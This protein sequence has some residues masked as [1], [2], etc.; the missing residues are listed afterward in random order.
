MHRKETCTS[1]RLLGL[2]VVF[3]VVAL[4][5]VAQVT[6]STIHGIVRDPSGAAIPAADLKLTDTATGIVKATIAGSEGT[7][8]FTNLVAGTYRL[9]ATAPGF[10]NAVLDGV[11][12]DAG[13]ITDV[14]VSMTV[15]STNETVEVAAVGVQLETTSNEI[16]TTISNNSIHNLPYP[17]RDSLFFALLMAGSAN[18]ND[19]SGR[20]STYNGLPN[21]SLNITIDGMNDNSQRFK[22]GGTSF[23]AFAPQR[24]DAIEEVTVSTT[25][26]GADAVGEGAMNVRFTTKRGTDHYHFLMGEQFENEALNANL[27]FA[28]LRGQHIPRGRQNNAYGSIG[29]PLVP[30]LPALKHKLFFF[31]YMEGQPQPSS[32]IATATVFT[33]AA[34]AGNFTYIGTDGATRTVNLLTSAAA[35]GYTSTV[36][37]TVAGILGAI[38]ASESKATGFLGIT[39]QPYWQTMQFV[40]PANTTYLFPTA[41]VDYQITPKVAWHG[42][43]NLKW[44]FIDGYSNYPDM[45]QYLNANSYKITTY[46]ATNSVDWTITPRMV[47]NFTFGVQSNLEFFNPGTNPYQWSIYG[48][49]RIVMPSFSGQTINPVVPTP[50]PINRNNPVFQV[51]D[52]LSWVKGQHT[53][54]IG[55]TMLHTSF[56]EAAY[57]SAGVP[58]YN[59]GLAS[60]D[61]VGTPLQ[62]ALPFINTVNGDLTNAQNLYALLT[63]RVA[64]ISGTVNV[65]E[66]TLQY[67]QFSPITNRFAF[68]TAGVYIQD[69]YRVSPRLALNFGVR[70][71]FDDTIKVANGIVGEPDGANFFGPSNGLF[72]PGVLN[73][74]LN[75][76]INNVCSPYSAD[77]VNPATNVGFAWNPSG[78]GAF[79]KLL[80]RGRTVIR[81]A[82]A[83]T[84]FNEGLD[85]ISNL[86][87]NNQGSTQS[88]SAV[89]GNAGFPLGGVNLSSPTP[90]LSVFPSAFG[91]PVPEA[92]YVFSG[93]NA[94][95]LINPHLVSP[96]VQ[97]WNLGIQRELPSHVAVE[98]RYVGNRST[99]QWHYQNINEVNIFENG[100]LP[101]FVQAQQN[102]AVNQANG[103]G[104]TFINNGLPGQGPIPIFET[105][106][107]ASGS[108]PALAAAS[109]FSN[110]GFI[111]NLQQGLAG[112]M[113]NSLASTSANTYYCRLVGSKFAPCANVGFTG[114]TPYPINFFTPN[115]FATSL[116]YQDDNGSNNYNG[117]QIEA[118]KA[119]THGLTGTVN[120]T[121]S[122]AMGNELN[123]S[124]DSATYT[125]FT[126]RNGRLSYG[127]SPF[128]RR[129]A[130]NSYWTYDLPFGKNRLINIENP[131]LDRVF[132]GWTLGGVETIASGAPNIVNSARMTVNNIGQSGV[133]LGSGLTQ[134]QF[135]QDLAS[136][137]DMNRVVNGNLIANVASIAQT[138]G[139]PNPTFY[140][141]ATTPG[142]FGQ[143]VYLYG[144]TNFAL[145]MSL[146]K[147]VRIREHLNIGFRVE[148]LNFLNHPFFPIGNTSPTANTFGQI[149]S[150]VSSVGTT[151]GTQNANF[152]RVVLLRAY[153]SW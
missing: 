50:L 84:Y 36:D 74:N 57:N 123:A 59:L 131:V 137:P 105:A 151:Y 9:T 100:F 111:T 119:T 89:P 104:V 88:I 112:S 118:R 83:L 98:F 71:Q 24:I 32:S 117:L 143:F 23:Y 152:N 10:Q 45:P 127:P 31:A 101:Q 30:F 99:H 8:S 67:S 106:F 21:A 75:P 29:G 141:P 77:L 139:I 109:G 97:N 147:Q 46:V 73:G 144:A 13:R 120:F 66:K 65:N 140:G 16:G 95:Y 149:S 153:L 22:S 87:P 72:Q 56:Y 69:N 60:G 42:S 61:P 94:L 3:S 55:A 64:S 82:Y 80:G 28:N 115:P 4:T 1:Y 17:S 53:L 96:Y 133:V 43:W 39:G 103:K 6:S 110:S 54:T 37:P 38:N 20:N 148:A 113:A 108:Q 76:V 78:E 102:L 125:W 124:S 18:A 150:T 44:D 49:R 33:A 2:A 114:T 79:G 48:N 128:D 146:N 19:T 52:N 129:L 5:S 138:N 126:M 135:R 26:L 130:F 68:T 34:Q 7:F 90:P 121:W 41:R 91:F 15:G 116:N 25:G 142:A 27:F 136:I 132:G 86:I 70:W 12:A 93:G 35:A 40:R 58:G 62:S 92:N 11:V 14:T 47:N 134:S 85:T 63:G 51:T 107:G 122:H 145:N 81:A